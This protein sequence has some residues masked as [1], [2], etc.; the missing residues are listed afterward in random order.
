[1][2]K[3]FLSIITLAIAGI[4]A[5]APVYADNRKCTMT[6]VLSNAH[7]DPDGTY[8]LP[9][10]DLNCFCGSD[11][12][13]SNQSSGVNEPNA[14]IDILRIVVNI[15][16]IG[17]GILGV[18]GITISGIQ[19]LTAGGSEERAKKA[20]RRMFEIILGLIAYVVVYAFLYWLIPEFNPNLDSGT[21]E[22]PTTTQQP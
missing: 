17:V 20:K 12:T 18:V 3:V 7:C 15:M 4:V 2:K 16:S 19:Y 11:I 13:G 8:V 14:I 6:S 10:G 5:V 9:S 1:M 22:T 21:T